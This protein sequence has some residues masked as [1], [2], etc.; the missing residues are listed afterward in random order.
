MTDPICL[1]YCNNKVYAH[2][3]MKVRSIAGIQTVPGGGGDSN[4]CGKDLRLLRI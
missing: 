3:N 1:S 4:P 2:I